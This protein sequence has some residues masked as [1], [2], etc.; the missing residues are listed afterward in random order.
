ME[1][2]TDTDGKTIGIIAYITLIGWVVAILMNSNKKNDYAS[3]HIR[4][5]LGLILLSIL[6]S[7]LSMYV[8]LGVFGTILSVL[9]LVLWIIGF[10]G[11]IQG[12]RKLVPIIGENFQEWFKGIK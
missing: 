2:T 6:V 1:N 12:E 5:M 3:F 10:V 8:N 7:V 11:A 9:I 4:Q